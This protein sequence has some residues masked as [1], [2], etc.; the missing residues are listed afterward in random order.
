M[1]R[2]TAKEILAESFRELA[3][4]MPFDRITVKD[5]IGNCG[6]SQ[7]TF[8]RQFRDKYDL[9]VWSYTQDFETIMEQMKGGVPS[10]RQTL[11]SAAAYYQQHKKYLANLLTHTSGY[12]SFVANMTEIHSKVLLNT[13]ERLSSATP[14]GESERACVQIYCYGTVLFSCDWILGKYDLSAK[15][16]ADC[17]ENALPELLLRY[18]K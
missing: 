1:K 13:L 5:I 14:V 17:Y 15:E 7:A 8:Y 16:L 3:Q 18:I 9:I 10:W 6:Y 12:D 2:K 4:S 11:D